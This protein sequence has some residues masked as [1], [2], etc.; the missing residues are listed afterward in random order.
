VQCAVQ[1]Q[2][3]VP[4]VRNRL[5]SSFKME[6]IYILC[7]DALNILHIVQCTNC[8]VRR[9]WL[10]VSNGG[11][12]LGRRCLAMRDITLSTDLCTTETNTSDGRSDLLGCRLRVLGTTPLHHS[13]GFFFWMDRLG[14]TKRGLHAQESVNSN[15]QFSS[16]TLT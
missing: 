9:I 15:A 2:N 4:C 14:L 13:L 12:S 6:T 3:R 11:I 5:S 16:T 7:N 1:F 8:I 10:R